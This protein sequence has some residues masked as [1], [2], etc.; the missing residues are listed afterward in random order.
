MALVVFLYTKL[1]H[2]LLLTILYFTFPT[3]VIQ[4]LLKGSQKSYTKSDMEK[5][6]RIKA[7]SLFSAFIG[8]GLALTCWA[9]PITTTPIN[10]NS[11]EGSLATMN[12]ILDSLYGL[13]NLQR[14]NDVGTNSDQIWSWVDG[15]DSWSATVQAKHAAYSHDFGILPGLESDNLITIVDSIYF[16]NTE[17]RSNSYLIDDSFQTF[18]LGLHVF[19]TD[20]TWS[21]QTSENLYRGL[22][23]DHMVTWQIMDNAGFE[24]NQIGNYVVA[25]EDLA[26][27]QCYYDGDYQD[28]VVELSGVQPG[29]PIVPEPATVAI[30]A[31]G[32]IFLVRRDKR[33]A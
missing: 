26:P 13:E 12:G 18:R 8:L 14:V 20:L 25:W 6:M 29:T 19:N 21:S 2:N 23:T 17:P 27:G 32:A 7:N 22:Y 28:L 30:L 31:A 5:T 11:S 3:W 9:T 10:T 15:V 33:R 4:G 1:S 24:D 16:N